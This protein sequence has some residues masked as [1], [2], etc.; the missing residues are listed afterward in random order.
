LSRSLTRARCA[1]HSFFSFSLSVLSLSDI[2]TLILTNR[3][4]PVSQRWALSLLVSSCPLLSPRRMNQKR[5]T[6]AGVKDRRGVTIQQVT[7]FS[8]PAKRLSELYS[9]LSGMTVGN[10]RF[11]EV[12]LSPSPRFLTHLTLTRS[13]SPTHTCT[14]TPSL[15]LSLSRSL[16]RSLSRSLALSLSLCH[17]L[18]F[19]VCLSVCLSHTQLL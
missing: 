13:H 14:P 18:S 7:A 2:V 4:T 5:F 16:A 3:P 6:Y 12:F 11:V 17:S 19:S 9:R 15:T 10:F 1:T 8:V